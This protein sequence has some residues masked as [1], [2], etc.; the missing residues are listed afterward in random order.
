MV[1]EDSS[2]LV[3]WWRSTTAQ[4]VALGAVLGPG[5][6][7]LAFLLSSK[8]K[9]SARTFGALKGSVAAS[10]AILVV[11]AIILLAVYGF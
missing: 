8:H 10:I 3:R 11:G 1:E 6:A 7:L 5:G 9:R 2:L 4:G